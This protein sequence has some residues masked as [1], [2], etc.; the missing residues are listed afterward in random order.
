MA[1]S[2]PSNDEASSSQVLNFFETYRRSFAVSRSGFTLIELMIV[3]AIIGILAS[4]AFPMYRGQVFKA[5]LV[6]VTNSMSSVA[7]AV[8]TYYHENQVWPTNN[9]NAAAIGSNLGVYVADI[10]ADWSTGGNPTTIQTTIKNISA[11]N[12][13]LDGCTLQLL[14]STGGNG[15]I[16]WTWAGNLPTAYIPNK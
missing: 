11:N 1:I 9:V 12:P 13:T 7:T 4:I 16:S 15:A 3:I 6:E 14:A 5:K 10:R 2:W 8:V